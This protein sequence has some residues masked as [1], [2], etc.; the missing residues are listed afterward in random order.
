MK[1]KKIFKSMLLPQFRNLRGPLF[2]KNRIPITQGCFVPSLVKIGRVVLKKVNVH[3]VVSVIFVI[4]L[5]MA[6]LFD[7]TILQLD[8]NFNS[9]AY[10]QFA[11]TF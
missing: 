4:S 2:R 3:N 1:K 10:I 7:L 5:L 8:L 11:I 9:L 6:C